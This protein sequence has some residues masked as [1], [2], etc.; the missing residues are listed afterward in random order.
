MVKKI[1]YYK[2]LLLHIEITS[3]RQFQCI[4]TTYVTENKENGYKV[5]TEPSIMSV[6][7]TSF[8]HLKLPISIKIQQIV[9]ILYSSY[10]FKFDFMDYKFANLVVAWL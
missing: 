1:I 3:M 9:F 6:V 10:Y 4:A 2:M 8:K 7:F 5:Y